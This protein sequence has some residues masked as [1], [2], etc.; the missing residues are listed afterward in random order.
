MVAAPFCTKLM[1]DLGADVVKVEPPGKGDPSRWRG[2]FPDDEVHPERSAL[3]LYLNTSKRSV[4]LDLASEAG[5]EI[6]ARLVEGVDVLVEDRKPG[7]MAALGLGY[8]DLAARDP[9][10]I[11]TSVTP[12]GQTGPRK[13]HRSQHL[14]L[15]HSSGHASPFKKRE[16]VEAGGSR[17]PA[18]AGG[19]LGEYDAGL[20]AAVATLG[21]V[22]GR[23][24]T[25]AGQNVDVSK[26]EAMMN[27]ERVIIG[28]SANAPDPFAGRS[29][30]GL[31]RAKDGYVNVITL[32]DH[33]WEGL[34]RAMGNPE[35]SRADW[36]Q[37]KASRQEHADQI[38]EQVGAW[39][40]GLTRDEIYHCVQA[41]GTPASPVRNVAEVMAW[42]QT[43]ARGF[44]RELPHPEAGTQLYPTAAYQ[45]SET[46]WAGARAPLLGEHND[47]IYG[48]ALGIPPAELESLAG[49]RV[50]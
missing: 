34:L 43:K 28:I 45:F 5:R 38:E 21:A 49:S 30:G 42:E 10:I 36:C 2:P 50:I 11:V 19:Y 15:Y 27:L 31:V 9:R 12:F 13:L 48:R 7:E 23:E 33:Q 8:D 44:F 46:P 41:E 47:A 40:A 14:N 20:S 16:A 25:G 26:Q 17:A 24:V 22:L 3:F 29:P 4:T 37:S 32:E 1:A 39:A 6:F 18:R 35:W